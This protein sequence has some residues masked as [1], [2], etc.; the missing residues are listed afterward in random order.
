MVSAKIVWHQKPQMNAVTYPR[1]VSHLYLAF[2]IGP[3]T[4]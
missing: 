1:P 4:C 2:L 3:L